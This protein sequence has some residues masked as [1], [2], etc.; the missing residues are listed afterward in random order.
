MISQERLVILELEGSKPE[1][2][3]TDLAMRYFNQVLEFSKFGRLLCKLNEL[4]YC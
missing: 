3:T 2:E 4:M 1:N